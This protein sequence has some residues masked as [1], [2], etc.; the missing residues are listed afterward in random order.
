MLSLSEE[1]RAV[2]LGI[3]GRYLPKVA[4][5]AYGSRSRGDSR[6]FS[7]LDLAILSERPLD[8]LVRDELREAFSESELP[9]RVDILDWASTTEAFRRSIEMDLVEFA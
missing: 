8:L 2:V 7:D 6:R 5:R 1:E 9:F 4:V 3:L